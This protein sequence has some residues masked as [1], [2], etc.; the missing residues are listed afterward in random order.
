MGLAAPR[1]A[2]GWRPHTPHGREQF[3]PTLRFLIPT[4]VANP[5]LEGPAGPGAV[6]VLPV[7]TATPMGSSPCPR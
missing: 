7:P 3:C 5:A 6:P 2:E 4:H 1:A